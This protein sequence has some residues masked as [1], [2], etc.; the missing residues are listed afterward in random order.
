M[1]LVTPPPSPAKPSSHVSTSRRLAFVSEKSNEDFESF[2]DRNAERIWKNWE[3]SVH[4][5]EMLTLEHLYHLV[6]LVLSTLDQGTL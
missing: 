2:G 6:S 1:R 4:Q 5:L 3:G